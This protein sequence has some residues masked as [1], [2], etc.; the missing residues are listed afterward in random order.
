[1]G[2]NIMIPFCISGV[3]IGTAS[4]T[5]AIHTLYG[6]IIFNISAIIPFN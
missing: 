1:M 5:Y 2:I 6:S 4:D 3:H